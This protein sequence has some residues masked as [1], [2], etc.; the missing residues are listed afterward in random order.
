[1]RISSEVI[2][3]VRNKLSLEQ[4]ADVITRYEHKTSV[5]EL[6]RIFK[7]GRTQIKGILRNRS[8]Y[9]K[10]LSRSTKRKAAMKN[11]P[12]QAAR[13]PVPPAQPQSDAVGVVLFEWVQRARCYPVSLTNDILR[14]FGREI[15]ERLDFKDFQC[16][17]SWLNHFRRKY[18]LTDAALK[19]K[20]A[21]DM[22]PGDRKP[23][24]VSAVLVDL[25]RENGNLIPTVNPDDTEHFYSDGED[26]DAHHNDNGL[27]V[28][29]L[30]PEIDIE[31]GDS[32]MQMDDGETIKKKNPKAKVDPAKRIIDYKEALKRLALLERFVLAKGNVRAVGIVNQLENLLR[33]KLGK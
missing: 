6:S 22:R 8:F 15:A 4:R 31:E 3:R 32:A 27:A 12:K 16:S 11:R 21:K 28:E 10:R 30:V 23:L 14:T 20:P 2:K 29:S 19:M 1:M 33:E 24:S 18:K 5:R 26:S 13:A 17:P 25:R 7:C 9:A